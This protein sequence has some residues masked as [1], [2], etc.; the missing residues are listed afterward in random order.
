[1]TIGNQWY[2]LFNVLSGASR[3]SHEHLE[4]AKVYRFSLWRRFRFIYLPT[5][6]PSLVTGWITAAGGAWNASI[7]AEMVRY[8]GGTMLAEGIGAQITLA[9]MSGDYPR[10]IAAVVVITIALVILNR[11]LWHTMHELVE[12]LA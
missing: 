7:V 11:T 5:I 12:R 1:M 8:P 2:L 10:L 9:T 3:I 6:F 4:V